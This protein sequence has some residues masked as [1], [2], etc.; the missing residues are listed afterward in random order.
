MEGFSNYL[1]LTLKYPFLKYVL[2]GQ[3]QLDHKKRKHYI[4]NKRLKKATSINLQ[5]FIV[6]FVLRIFVASYIFMFP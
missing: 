4:I 1:V 2:K 6:T 5:N 3:T